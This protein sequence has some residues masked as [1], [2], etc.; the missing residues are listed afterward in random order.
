MLS[1]TSLFY[2]TM[3]GS[4]EINSCGSYVHADI[5]TNILCRRI[6]SWVALLHSED[7]RV[8][9][10]IWVFLIYASQKMP[11]NWNRSQHSYRQT[12]CYIP[13]FIRYS[14]HSEFWG[15]W[16]TW[17]LFFKKFT[18]KLAVSHVELRCQWHNL[19]PGTKHRTQNTHDQLLLTT[20]ISWLWILQIFLAS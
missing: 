18:L 14:S 15:F 6:S 2:V 8:I 13:V 19:V 7:I 12:S 10:N 1:Q 4:F 20:L 9:Q 16:Y 5:Y 3:V 11:I 17:P